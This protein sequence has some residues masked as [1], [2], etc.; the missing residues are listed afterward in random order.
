VSIDTL[1]PFVRRLAERAEQRAYNWMAAN[2]PDE[3]DY[4]DTIVYFSGV[5]AEMAG[6]LAADWYNNQDADTPKFTARLDTDM[7]EEKLDNIAAWVFEGPQLPINRGRLAAHRIVF[8]AARRTVFAAAA[9]EG[10]GVARHEGATSC[11]KCVVRA[12]LDPRDKKSSSED[13]DQF[14]H[15]KCEGLFVPIRT[16]IYEPPSHAVEWRSKVAAARHAGNTDPEDIALWIKQ[17]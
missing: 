17:H 8:D 16:G 9:E 10:V 1:K 12:T 4:R 15:P 2:D 7:P 6:L 3:T 5:Y 14:F 13:V 11:S